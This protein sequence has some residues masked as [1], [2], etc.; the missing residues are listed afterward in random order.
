MSQGPT[1]MGPAQVE[2]DAFSKGKGHGKGDKGQIK[3]GTNRKKETRSTGEGKKHRQART[4]DKEKGECL[5]IVRISG[6]DE[7]ARDP[8]LR[9][10]LRVCHRQ[11]LTGRASVA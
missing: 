1:P 5:P 11:C 10:A 4:T 7:E 8:E 3:G 2:V 9:N 6:T